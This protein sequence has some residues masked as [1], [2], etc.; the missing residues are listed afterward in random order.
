MLDAHQLNVFLTAAKTLNYTAAARQLHMTQPSVSQHIHALEQHFGEELFARSGRYMRLTDAGMALL[1]MAQKMVS[2]SEHIEETM[3][4]LKGEVHGH[5]MVGCSTT[6]GKYVL[7]SLLASFMRQYPQVQASCLVTPRETA[8]QMLCEGDV[9][10][11]LASSREFCKDVEFCKFIDDPVVLIAPLDH[12]WA[13]RTELKPDELLQAQ[14][15]MREKKSGTR[16]VVE[17]GLI[18]LGISIDQ[19]NMKLT[20]GNSE[21]IA[22]A[23]QEG[24]GVGFVSR[25]VVTRLVP[26]RV[27]QVNVRGLNIH[28]DIYIGSHTGRPATTAQAAFWHFVTDPHN[29]VLERLIATN[30][31]GDWPAFTTLKTEEPVLLQS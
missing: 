17:A 23:V 13:E 20:L 7:P 21:A 30:V 9:H 29:P 25:M 3:D 27:A 11:A 14:F 1:P 6:V 16:E 24:I 15:I 22:L 26:D 19:L 18:D 12:P 31:N 4:S 8:V 2:I 28:Q 5:L 10:I